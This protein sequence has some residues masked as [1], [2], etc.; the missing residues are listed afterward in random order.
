MM[1]ITLEKVDKVKERTGATYAEAKYALEVNNGD[2]LDA[3]IYLEE[4]KGNNS[5]V[6]KTLPNIENSEKSS[7]TVDELKVWLKDLINK[8]N[9][10][11]IRI[12][13]EE[14]EIIDV[15][16]NAGIAAGVIAVIVPQ[17]LAFGLIAAVATQIRIELTMSDGTVEVVNK[18]VSKAVDD[19]K[20]VAT[21]MASKVKNKVSGVKHDTLR[22]NREKNKLYDSDEKV[23]SYTVNFDDEE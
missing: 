5:E 3:I 12:Y 22:Q 4:I 17:I 10:T 19:I 15:P 2:I 14:K 1:G 16:V 6:L 7:E 20:D 9:I 11:R 8:G 23:Y 18:Y 13:K 21:E